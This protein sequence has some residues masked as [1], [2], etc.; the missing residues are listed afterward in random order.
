MKRLDE[1]P[2]KTLFEVPDG[3]FEKLPGRIQARVSQPEPSP[4]WGSLAL[5]YALPVVVIGVV[6]AVLFT[7][8]PE[9]S[10]E[11][12]I[13]GIESEQL[14]AYL[15]DLEVNTDDLL[16]AVPLDAEEIESLELDA[17]GEYLLDESAIN[18]WDE[19]ERLDSAEKP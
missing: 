14:V 8:T 18:A 17:L 15:D 7:R 4:A 1:I 5:R 6:A 12:V 9:M 19:L 2:K 16:D 13:A 3:Y 10:P 11:Q